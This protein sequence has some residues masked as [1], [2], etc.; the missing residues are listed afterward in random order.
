[1]CHKLAVLT[2]TQHYTWANKENTKYVGLEK[3]ITMTRWFHQYLCC[4]KIEQEN[5]LLSKTT[6][7]N[8]INIL[9]I[10]MIFLISHKNVSYLPCLYKYKCWRFKTIALLDMTLHYGT[11]HLN[12]IVIRYIK[13]S[14][15]LLIYL[16]RWIK[17]SAV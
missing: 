16:Y 15:H 11:S 1:M 10:T 17:F 14:S 5:I 12:T 6:A 13:L 2:S 4:K 9:I 8:A 7:G 3:C